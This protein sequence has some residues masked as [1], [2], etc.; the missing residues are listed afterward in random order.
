[1][2]SVENTSQAIGPI[3]IWLVAVVYNCPELSMFNLVRIPRVNETDVAYC[4]P[5]NP[6]TNMRDF[7]TV[8]FVLWYVVPLSV[9]TFMYLRI[10]CTLWKASRPGI[11]KNT[12]NIGL[13]Q[14]SVRDTAGA[15]QETV[16]CYDGSVSAVFT[17][18]VPK[19]P[20][21]RECSGSDG[22]N[23]GSGH[24]TL[25][26][27]PRYCRSDNNNHTMVGLPFVAEN[28]EHTRK[29]V[30]DGS[31]QPHNGTFSGT[32]PESYLAP[33]RQLLHHQHQ[34]QQHLNK[35]HQQQHLQ[36]HPRQQTHQQQHQ[37]QKQQQQQQLHHNNIQQHFHKPR[38]S[39][40]RHLACDFTSDVSDVTSSEEYDMLAANGAPSRRRRRQYQMNSERVLASRLRVVRLL[41]IVLLTFAICV[42]PYHVKF[43][44][45]F[46]HP[47]PTSKLDIL[48]P[49]SFAMLYMNSALNPILYW[50]FSD[51]FRTSF[52]DTCRRTCT[53]CRNL[54]K[55]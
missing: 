21:S 55:V 47:Q 25:T 50:V 16:L 22:S 43:L 20:N 49:L 14:L 30:W 6:Y 19:A 28:G 27:T 4:F 37:Q 54:K 29:G 34:Y 46:W 39:A 2:G 24:L 51:S 44:I 35:Q 42:F 26:D 15:R 11:L 41:V 8:N 33:G 7:Y 10:S 40:R 52:K 1:M 12:D 45:M 5:T 13:R 31:V 18:K 23:G 53:S 36:H 17:R 3:L 32:E 48:S 38:R 9:M